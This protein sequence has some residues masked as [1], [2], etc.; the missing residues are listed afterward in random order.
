MHLHIEPRDREFLQRL[1]R[2]GGGTIQDICAD[3]GVTA[4]AVRQRLDRLQA[5]GFV[6]REA[7][8]EGRGRP[9]YIYEPSVTGLRELGENY[10]E[11]AM[12]LWR[13]VRQIEPPEVREAVLGN[14]RREMVGRFRQN[15]H[16]DG[17]RQRLSE[18]GHD[19]SEQ[20]FD[21]EV[22]TTGE[23]PILRGHTCPYPELAHSDSGICELEQEV[24]AEVVGA[25]VRLS[26]CC[27]DGSNCCEFELVEQES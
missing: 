1:H 5:A 18:L 11:L 19:L 7:V 3:L 17:S 20:G 9:H 4:T 2:L 16:G 6:V 8:R 10:A 12:T 22:D 24:F 27:L 21:V 13:A 23:L 15:I 25:P 14:V 26:Q